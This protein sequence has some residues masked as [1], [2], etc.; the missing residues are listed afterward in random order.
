MDKVTGGT[1]P[2]QTWRRFMLAATRSMPVRSLPKAPL[3]PA[4]LAAG[5]PAR[6]GGGFFENLLGLFRPAP[7]PEPPRLRGGP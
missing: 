4:S 6:S 1:L 2:A 3:P 5:A 7:P